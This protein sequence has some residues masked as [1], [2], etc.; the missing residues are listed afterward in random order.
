MLE[1]GKHHIA[2]GVKNKN[3]MKEEKKSN[4]ETNLPGVAF[5]PYR[6]KTWSNYSSV[7]LLF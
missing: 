7:P 4:R 3:G 5:L 6:D 1:V 2:R